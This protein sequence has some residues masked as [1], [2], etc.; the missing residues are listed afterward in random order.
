MRLQLAAFLCATLFATGGTLT[1]CDQ[2]L[3]EVEIRK[4]FDGFDR[5]ANAGNVRGFAEYMA[6]DIKITQGDSV[7]HSQTVH[8]SIRG[9]EGTKTSF[10]S[11]V[12]AIE[13]GRILIRSVS[14][15]SREPKSS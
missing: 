4:I 7:T 8:R 11:Y 3:T 5:A 10:Q 14:I 13:Q 1:A 6:P 15:W 12:F 2:R 9:Q